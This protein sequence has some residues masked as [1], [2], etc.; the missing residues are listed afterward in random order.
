MR[1]PKGLKGSSPFI[2]T[3]YKFAL[4][5]GYGETG[6]HNA[7]PFINRS[8][9]GAVLFLTANVTFPHGKS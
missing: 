2:P 9:K 6:K 8:A 7:L 3:K 1:R 4:N 5:R